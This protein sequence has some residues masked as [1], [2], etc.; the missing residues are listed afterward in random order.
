M[1]L[2]VG[3]T[4]ETRVRNQSPLTP[5]AACTVAAQ[6]LSALEAG[7]RAGIIHRDIKPSSA[8]TAQQNLQS[9]R[10]FWA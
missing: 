4:L 2:L 7:H 6:T 3:K 9:Q 10:S 1:E 8:Q 5:A